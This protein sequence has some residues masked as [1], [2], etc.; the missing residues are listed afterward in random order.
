MHAPCFV[1][2][3]D[4]HT[5]HQGSDNQCGHA[6]AMRCTTTRTAS[7]GAA[8]LSAGAPGPSSRLLNIKMACFSGVHTVALSLGRRRWKVPLKQLALATARRQCVAETLEGPGVTAS[9]CPMCARPGWLRELL[10]NRTLA[11][12]VA[13][14]AEAE[15]TGAL[16]QSTARCLQQTVCTCQAALAWLALTGARASE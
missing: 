12:L 5:R 4:A 15:R 10:P 9:Q 6:P 14:L 8:T 1:V 3:P 11:A 7:P 13:C 16:V 2:P